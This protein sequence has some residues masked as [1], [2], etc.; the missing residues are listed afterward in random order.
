MPIIV[1]RKTVLS[2]LYYVDSHSRV[3]IPSPSSPVID[4]S[5]LENINAAGD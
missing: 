4:K 1:P 3:T 5:N 2:L